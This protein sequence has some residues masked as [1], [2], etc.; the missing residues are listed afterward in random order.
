MIRPEVAYRVIMA[1]LPNLVTALVTDLLPIAAI[2]D[3][4]RS[5]AG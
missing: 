4:V 1:V 5:I 2:L 3:A